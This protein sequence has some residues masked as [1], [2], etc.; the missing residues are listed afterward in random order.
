MSAWGV[1]VRSQPPC[2]AIL[3]VASEWFSFTPRAS[4]RCASRPSCEMTSL[5]SW[6]AG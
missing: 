4:R 5:S 3:A 2:F 6:M 1:L